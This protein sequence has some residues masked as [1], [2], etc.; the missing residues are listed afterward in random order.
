[1]KTGT[2]IVIKPRIS[3]SPSEQKGPSYPPIERRKSPRVPITLPVMDQSTGISAKIVD[4][5]EGGVRRD[6]LK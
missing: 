4:L 3:S 6:L 5:S 1:M 2:K